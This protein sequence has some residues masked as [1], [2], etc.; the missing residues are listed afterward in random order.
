MRRKLIVLGLVILV[1]EVIAMIAMSGAMKDDLVIQWGI[2][3]YRGVMRGLLALT[4][5]TA[6]AAALGAA[7]EIRALRQAEK[8]KAGEAAAQE[9]QEGEDSRLSVKKKL[10]NHELREI[11]Q[12]NAAGQWHVIQGEISLCVRQLHD[13]DDDQERLN[14]LLRHN[15]AQVLSDTEDVLDQVE[16]LMCRNV[17]KAIN[18]MSISR[19]DRQEDVNRVRDEF[20]GCCSANGE[21][22]LDVQEFLVALTEFLNRQGESEID[23]TMLESYKNMLRVSVEKGSGE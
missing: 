8:A 7:F 15:D 21:L 16:Q 14:I 23:V 3:K 11:L 9:E 10:R 18:Y 6:A 17:R 5:G 1:A 12:E 20:A 22:L 2:L 19:S 13:M 4:I